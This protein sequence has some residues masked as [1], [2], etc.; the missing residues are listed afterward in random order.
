MR[1]TSAAWER[2]AEVHEAAQGWLRVGA[3]DEPTGHAIRRAF[4]DPC[5]TP[6]A[7]WRVLTACVVAAVILCTFEAFSIAFRP[8]NI[9]SQVLLFLFAGASLVAADLLETSPRF[10]RR[11]AAGAASFLGVGFLLAGFGRF[12][13]VTMMMRLDDALD[14]VLIASVLAWTV[15]C[16][17][18][19][20]PLFA[21]LSA[22]S[23][24]LFLGR[25]PYGRLLWALVGAALA[26]LAAR[27]LDETSLAPSHRRAAAVLVVA[28]IMA[29]YTAVNVYSFEAH[30]LEYLNFSA[31]RLIVPSR[32][33]VALAALATAVLPPAVLVWGARSRRTFL[34]DTGIVLLALSLVTLRHYVHIAPLWAMLIVSGAALVILA[35]TVDRAL[36]RA[37]TGDIAGFTADPLF[38]DERRQHALQVV[39]VVA[40]FTSAEPGPAAQEKDFTGGGGKFGG[41]G[42]GEKF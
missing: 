30:L 14:A 15:S 7:V 22:I 33:L 26:G 12:L 4:P 32:G 13:L 19:G 3:I 8:G 29:A 1:Q 35:L 39:P 34:L 16:R 5:I 38:S 18:W 10:A 24:F 40:A 31:A 20:S 23:L 41:G 42:A 21:A 6:S 37:P 36:R 27:R 2:A 9:G 17:R 25:L 28:G 11:G